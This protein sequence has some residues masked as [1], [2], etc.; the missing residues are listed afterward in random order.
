M[1]HDK[2]KVPEIKIGSNDLPRCYGFRKQIFHGIWQGSGANHDPEHQAA[3]DYQV[4]FKVLRTPLLQHVLVGFAFSNRKDH[5]AAY[6]IR[7]SNR[8]RARRTRCTDRGS[9]AGGL[10]AVHVEDL[11]QCVEVKPNEEAISRAA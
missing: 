11:G 6:R 3:V 1:M 7:A 5:V 8:G 9:G 2:Y 10:Q 4:E